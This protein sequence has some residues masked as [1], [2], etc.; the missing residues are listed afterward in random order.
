MTI[1]NILTF[2]RVALIP[3]LLVLLFLDGDTTR[4][5]ALALYLALAV[6]DYLD[7]YLARVLNQ[8]SELGALIDP[9]ADKI[10]VAA[11]I[12]ALVGS[13]DIARWD[14]AAAILVLSREFLVSGLREFLA[15]RDLPLPVT[16]LAKWKTTI[17]LIA[18]ALFILPPLD[19]ANQALIASSVWWIAT[20]LTLVTGYGY[21][22]SATRRLNHRN[23]DQ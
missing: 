17:Q 8:Q 14:I 15:Q 2:A 5:W 11:L 3:L 9:I 20:L 22:T 19:I 21:V 4:W 7:G 23:A 18:I 13:G 12:V 1:P 16:K 6:T 10:L